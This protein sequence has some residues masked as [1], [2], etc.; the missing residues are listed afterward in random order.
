MT[1]YNDFIN[2]QKIGF[3]GTFEDFLKSNQAITM[4]SIEESHNKIIDEYTKNF[5]SQVKTFVNVYANISGSMNE[6]IVKSSGQAIFSMLKAL[7]LSNE[8]YKVLNNLVKEQ[9]QGIF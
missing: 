1:L 9:F 4:P 6:I 5:E 7:N 2:L 8:Q 3:T